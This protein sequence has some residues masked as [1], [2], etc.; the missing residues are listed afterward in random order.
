MA[1]AV[2]TTE[3]I[4]CG[5]FVSNTADKQFLLFTRDAGMIYASARSV[6]EERSRQRYAL[7]DFSRIMVSLVRGKAG[8]RI[9]SVETDQNFFLDAFSREARG[10]VVKL[11]RLVRRFVQGEESHPELFDEL[12]AQLAVLMQVTVSDRAHAEAVAEVR[13]LQLLGYI[14]PTPV[15]KTLFQAPYSEA[16]KLDAAVYAV[17]VAAARAQ[18]DAASH[19]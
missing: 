3:A 6:R 18:A 1:Y 19:L 2:Y 7:Q 9:G 13:I 11:I 16:L 4:V 12:S 17:D 5:S 14:S 8:W 15:L 10:S